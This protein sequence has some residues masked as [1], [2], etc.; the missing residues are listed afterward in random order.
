M[1]GTMR[2][3]DVIRQVQR[4]LCAV[5]AAHPP[6][7]SCCEVQAVNLVPN[8]KPQDVYTVVL[9]VVVDKASPGG[10]WSVWGVHTDA[11]GEK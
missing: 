9:N 1:Q 11:S 3:W 10:G 2:L 5:S 7:W 4:P 6:T 8:D